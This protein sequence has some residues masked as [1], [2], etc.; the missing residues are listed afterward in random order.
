VVSWMSSIRSPSAFLQPAHVSSTQTRRLG[1]FELEL[2]QAF[3][4]Q[5]NLEQEVVSSRIATWLPGTCSC[6]R[7]NNPSWR[8]HSK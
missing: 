6:V 1:L 8:Y 5:E 4:W 2:L 3:K 7:S